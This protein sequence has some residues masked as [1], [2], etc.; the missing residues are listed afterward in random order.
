MTL[1]AA[2]HRSR[3]PEIAIILNRLKLLVGVPI[4]MP[5]MISVLY[6]VLIVMP[7]MITV[8]VGVFSNS[9]LLWLRCL[10]AGLRGRR[11]TLVSCGRRVG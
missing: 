7:S 2:R 9:L 4:V 1:G 5:S 10:G 11:S 3:D 6:G 8:L